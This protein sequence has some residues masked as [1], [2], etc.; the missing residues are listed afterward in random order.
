MI[1]YAIEH[2]IKE[3]NSTIYFGGFRAFLTVK[4]FK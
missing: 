4:G 2:M 3:V 1:Y